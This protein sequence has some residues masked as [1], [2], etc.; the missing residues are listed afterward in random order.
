MEKHA[1]EIVDTTV[2]LL[3]QKVGNR[4]RWRDVL[5]EIKKGEPDD[6]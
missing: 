3:A 1:N 2:L 5:Q 6:E 4:K